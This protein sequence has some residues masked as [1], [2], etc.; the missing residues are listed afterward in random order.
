M[1]LSPR[2]RVDKWRGG[3]G[4]ITKEF[5]ALLTA[6]GYQPTPTINGWQARC[7]GHEDENPSLCISEGSDGRVLLK[8]QAGCT[9]QSV[10]DAI[11]IKLAD[12]FPAKAIPQK[13]RLIQT[14]D[15]NAVAGDL[16]FQVCRYDPKSFRQ[17]RPD[18]KGGWIWSLKGVKRVLYRLPEVIEANAEGQT[19]CIVEGEK[20]AN[21]LAELGLC[22]TCNAGGAEKWEIS[23]SESL[24]GADVVILPD[25]DEPGRKH[26]AKVRQML[27]DYANTVRVVELPDR[28]GHKVKDAADWTAAGG[29]REELLRLVAS[30]PE[31]DRKTEAKTPAPVEA[32]AGIGSLSGFI[33]PGGPVSIS[34]SAR[35]I[36]Q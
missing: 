8:C 15:Y 5:V 28:N 24:R 16:L 30:A 31:W 4:V 2:H 36:F 22:A 25:K 17:R 32:E 35:A 1:D 23:Y 19:I 11:G 14:Y 20:D 34:K 21:A 27:S 13:P 26:A 33:L 18:G 6:R 9:A 12:L 10:C 7:P 29:T 3:G